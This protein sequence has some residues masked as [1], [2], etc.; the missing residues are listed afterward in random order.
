MTKGLQ[1]LQL[2]EKHNLTEAAYNDITNVFGISEISLYRMRNAL[3]KL[4]PFEPILVDCCINSCIAFTGE[5]EAF[6]YCPECGK[7]DTELDP[8]RKW[9][10]NT[11]HIGPQLRRYVYSTRKRTVLSFSSTDIVMSNLSMTRWEIFM[12]VYGTNPL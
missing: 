7:R 4:V 11:H 6:T 1:L 5:Y 10:E 2:R 9:H 3:G 12:M 8:G